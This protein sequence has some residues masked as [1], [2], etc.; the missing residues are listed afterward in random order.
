MKTE[1]HEVKLYGI[2]AASSSGKGTAAKLQL[3][4]LDVVPSLS[5]T[6]IWISSCPG[7]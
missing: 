7:A 3:S 6:S 1:L 2:G 4:F 5:I